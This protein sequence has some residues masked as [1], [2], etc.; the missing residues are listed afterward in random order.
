MN[1]DEVA[2]YIHESAKMRILGSSGMTVTR[3]HLLQICGRFVVFGLEVANYD[4]RLK[5]NSKR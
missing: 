4:R 5:E 2:V 1:N 3:G